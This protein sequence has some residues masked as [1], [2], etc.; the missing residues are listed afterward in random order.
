MI[1]KGIGGS[2]VNIASIDSMHPSSEGLVAYDASK[3]GVLT[4]TKSLA[5][6]LG[7]YDI[8]VNAVAPGVILTEGV[9]SQLH[10]TST[11]RDKAE[12]KALMSR[13]VLGRM[14]RADDVSRVVL[15]L[16]SDLA[17]YMTGSV[18]VVDGGYLIS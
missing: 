11:K 9:F 7:Q 3:G 17:S 4:L 13:M 15:F 2:I 10:S 5:L 1:A 16:V 6:E 8:R 12:L 14:G 18:V